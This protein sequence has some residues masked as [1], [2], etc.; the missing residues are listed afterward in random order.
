MF[1]SDDQIAT[2]LIAADVEEHDAWRLA[3]QARPCVWLRT[4]S[5]IDEAEIALGTTEMGGRA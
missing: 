5:V 2:G 3:K 1:T 4:N